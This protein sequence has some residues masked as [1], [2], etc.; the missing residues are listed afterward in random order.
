[1][2]PK[3]KERGKMGQEENR[4]WIEDIKEGRVQLEDAPSEIIDQIA[5]GEVSIESESSDH[6]G[7]QEVSEVDSQEQSE[8]QEN[9]TPEESQESN[10]DEAWYKRKNYE[11]SNELN[12]ERQRRQAH[13][14]RLKNDA[15]YR[16]QYL[17]ELGVD[18]TPSNRNSEES[19][20]SLDDIDVY[21]ESVLKQTLKELNELKAWKL[22]KEK[23]DQS[24]Q[25]E[26]KQ[27][28]RQQESRQKISMIE[29]AVS[30]SSLRTS[31]PFS[32]LNDLVEAG[33]KTPE[34]LKSYGVSDEDIQKLSKIYQAAN[35]QDFLRTNDFQYALHKTLGSFED[36]VKQVQDK[37]LQQKKEQIKSQ[38]ETM[39]TPRG[40][41]GFGEQSRDGM[42]VDL[43][44]QIVQKL[45]NR[46]LSSLRKDERSDLENAWQVL[47][48]S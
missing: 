31:V 15:L 24:R 47:G 34:Q 23:E 30:N 46:D 3:G 45:E 42:S 22:Q 21:D 5:N 38:T 17:K 33:A 11:L 29:S 2:R 6:L 32:Q 39:S 16:E 8:V 40:A 26:Q 44:L 4:N 18:L 13:E 1:M 41:Q 35:S 19:E 10:D 25:Y 12:T 27:S 7:E 9:I 36:P 28:A 43:A 48:I 14:Q 37:M 20:Q